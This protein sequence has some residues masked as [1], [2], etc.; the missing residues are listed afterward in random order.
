MKKLLVSLAICLSLLQPAEAR[1][2]WHY[3]RK[4][5]WLP[6]YWVFSLPISIA[7]WYT[8]ADENTVFVPL[9]LDTPVSIYD[10]PSSSK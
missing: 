9:S 7:V 1:S 4:A 3:V 5:L 2:G 6:V 8:I 10:D